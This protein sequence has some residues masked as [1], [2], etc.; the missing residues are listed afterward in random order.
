[1]SLLEDFR[2]KLIQIEYAEG[3]DTNWIPL[4]LQ[5]KTENTSLT[6]E[7]EWEQKVEQNVCFVC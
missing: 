3:G 2:E 5:T 1:M 6:G 4:Y 7:D